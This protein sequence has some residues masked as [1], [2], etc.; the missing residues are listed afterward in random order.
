MHVAGVRLHI[1]VA[2]VRLVL[3]VM[4]QEACSTAKQQERD[5]GHQ[6]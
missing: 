1:H 6:W 2:G 3:Y 5:Q 4:T